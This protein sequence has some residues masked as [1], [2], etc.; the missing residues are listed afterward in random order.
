M[1]IEKTFDDEVE[2]YCDSCDASTDS[3]EFHQV[4]ST[5]RQDGWRIEKDDKSGDWNHICP[6][7]ASDDD[8][9][10]MKGF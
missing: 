8:D 3:D 4:I 7:C 10:L 5:A 6:S 1:T 9:E 2:M